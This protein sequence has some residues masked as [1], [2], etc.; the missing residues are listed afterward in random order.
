M[1]FDRALAIGLSAVVLG[2]LYFTVVCGEENQPSSPVA[3]PLGS[4]T[5]RVSAFDLP[6][7]DFLSAETLATL[8]LRTK[9]WEDVGKH[10]PVL[11]ARQLSREDVLTLRACLDQYRAPLIIARHKALYKV[12][13]SR[14]RIGG[15]STEIVTPAEGILVRNRQRVLINLHGGGFQVMGVWGGEEESIPIAAVGRIKVV[16]VDYRMAPEYQFPAASE[17][18]AA[19]YRALLRDYTPENIGIYGCSAGGVLTAES[20]AWFQKE[21]LPTPGAIGMFCAG[22]LPFAEG[23]SSYFGAAIAGSASTQPKSA[24]GESEPK[25]PLLYFRPADL[26]NPLAFPGLAPQ[27]VARFPPSLLITATRDQCMSSVVAT[28]SL[29]VKLGVEA[30]LHVWEGLGHGFFFEPDLPESREAYLVIAH[31]FDAHLGKVR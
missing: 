2:L 27:V 18:V 22:A 11:F 12:D 8:K 6:P 4:E 16:S 1:K 25:T 15:I 10:C 26:K 24:R 14:Q 5:V 29:L 30:E 13:I 28:H 20:V 19:V 17:D 3:G 7:S 21:G 23:D 9:E 31:F